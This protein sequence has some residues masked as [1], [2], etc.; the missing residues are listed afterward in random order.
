MK[1]AIIGAGPIGLSL[2]YYLSQHDVTI[3]EKE[4]EIGGLARPFSYEGKY[5]DRYYHFIFLNDYHTIGL[6]KELGIDDKIQWGCPS[7]GVY[8]KGKTYP[9]STI[10]DLLMFQNMSLSAKAK[11]CIGTFKITHQKKWKHLENVNGVK[12]LMNMYGQEV[13]SIIWEPLMKKKFRDHYNHIGATWCWN[14]IYRRGKSHKVIGKEK[15][16]YFKGGVKDLLDAIEDRLVQNNVHICKNVTIQNIIHHDDFIEIVTD[17]KSYHYDKVLA[18]IPAQVINR[19]LVRK[20][21]ITIPMVDYLSIRCAVIFLKRKISNH[22]WINIC[23]GN[24]PQVILNEFTNLN[25]VEQNRIYIPYYVPYDSS[26]Y[27]MNDEGFRQINM[28][29]LKTICSDLREDDI[30]HYESFKDLY[31]QAVFDQNYSR[32]IFPYTTPMKNFF[33]VNNSQIYPERS[34]INESIRFAKCIVGGLPKN[35]HERYYFTSE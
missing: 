11:F 28:N 22:F 10:Y 33:L 35:L 5:Y 18:T 2:A 29:F 7:M 12:W 14:E 13:F 19:L 23:D 3:F 34:G 21:Q 27:Q 4:A 9:F 30:L 25:M 8:F 6:A 17:N 1:I 31:A 24:L 32:K 15:L 26:Y 20:F 16:G